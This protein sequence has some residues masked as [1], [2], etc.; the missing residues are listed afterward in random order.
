MR[1]KAVLNCP[2][3]AGCGGYGSMLSFQDQAAGERTCGLHTMSRIED[4]DRVTALLS[5]WRDG[6]SGALARLIPI[7]AL[8][9]NESPLN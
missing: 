5:A 3:M 1:G 2:D 4:S 7:V 6:D 9:R 8:Y